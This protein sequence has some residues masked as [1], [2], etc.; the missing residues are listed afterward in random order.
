MPG[1][2]VVG[3]SLAVP[4][5]LDCTVMPY[6]WGSRTAI[7]TL[8]GRPVPSPTPEAELWMGAHPLA[9]S[10][11][12][13]DGVETDLSAVISAN[14]ARELGERVASRFGPRLPFLM[15]VLAAEAPLSLQAHPTEA[16]ARAG[17]AEEERRA[18]PLTAPDRNYKDPHHKPELISALTPF[19]A[20]C[21]FRDALETLA[22]FTELAVP[23]LKPVLVPLRESPD[24][25]GLGAMFQALMTW[26]A[27]AAARA[28]AAV[29]DACRAYRGTFEP[30]CRWAVRLAEKYPGDRGVV[31]AL[32][33]NR[34][35][36]EPGEAIYL[37]AGNLHA[38]LHGV[39]IEIMA[40]SDN[41]LRGGLTPKHVDVAELLKVLDFR[42]G[43]VG[44]LRPRAV[45][46]EEA[47]WDTPAPEFRLS[48][49][50]VSGAGIERD[51][52]G[53][54]IVLCTEGALSVASADRGTPLMVE[55]G[56][57]VF[58]A[59]DA[60]RYRLDGHGTA[61]RAATNL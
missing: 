18:V 39:G 36:L 60:R 25:S 3:Y 13:R 1:H 49:I 59:A 20:L 11:L 16:Q 43:P 21:G 53:P 33:L 37:G 10:R 15:K 23:T 48:R 17:F 14:A 46:A 55:R 54:E 41:V 12:T 47:V 58:V 5:R 35:H 32:M 38:Y 44:V 50:A 40:S 34:V 61:F 24:A 29:V 31:G 28:T 26:P 6:A 56:M 30:E 8:Q 19:D 27:D 4:D 57:A 7:A 45:D 9:P 22:L 42:D 2:A 51:V 52:T